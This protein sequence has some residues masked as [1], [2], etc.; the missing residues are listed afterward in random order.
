MARGIAVMS[1]VRG[2]SIELGIIIIPHLSGILM[3]ISRVT[4]ILA[5][6]TKSVFNSR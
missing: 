5:K 6:F 1:I 4:V 2:M 3:A